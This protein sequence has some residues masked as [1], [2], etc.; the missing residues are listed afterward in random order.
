MPKAK[1]RPLDA[2]ALLQADHAYVKKAF[3]AFE[4][5]DH[6]DTAEMAKF[7]KLVCKELKVH[8]EIE[9]R[10]FYPAL[11]KAIREPD[12]M[13]EAVI[14]HGSAKTLIRQIERMKPRNP[15]YAAAFTVLGEYVQHH[16]KE[17]E[18]EMFP[19]ARRARLNRRVLGEKLLARKT[20]LMGL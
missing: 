6:A 2:I 3:K 10:I 19:K 18:S 12:L 7:V 9:E 14:E 16:V 4:K 5:M 20:R 1:A 13:N 17:E 15:M 11:R 8:T